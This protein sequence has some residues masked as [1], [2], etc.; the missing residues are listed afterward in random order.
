MGAH[1]NWKTDDPAL[2]SY[3]LATT[4]RIIEKA[5][6]FASE[7]NKK[8]LF[9]LSYSSPTIATTIT[10][11]ERFDAALVGW[12]QTTGLPFVD[13][14]EAH[15]KDFAN[16]SCSVEDY[17]ARFY[18][19][20]Y[21]TMGNLFCAFA[22]RKPLLE[23]LRSPPPR[24]MVTGNQRATLSHGHQLMQTGYGAR[25]GTW[26]HNVEFDPKHQLALDAYIP[27]GDGPFP[28]VV[29][30]HGGG[31]VR[32]TKIS[33]LDPLFAPLSA[34][35]FAWFTV[36]YRMA[37]SGTP[38]ARCEDLVAD[39]ETA[40]QWIKCHA[41]EYRIDLNRTALCGE[42]AG[43]HL[44]SLAGARMGTSQQGDTS[45]PAVISFYGP[46]NLE[47]SV[48]RRGGVLGEGLEA[49]FG[50][51]GSTEE[52]M[53]RIR[54]GSPSTHIHSDMPPY[55]LIHGTADEQVHYSQ[56]VEFKAAM[57]EL[58]NDVELVTLHGARHGMGSWAG[59]DGMYIPQM[60]EWLGRKLPPTPRED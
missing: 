23:L 12:L 22:L 16:F 26:Y 24:S 54:A 52:V 36:E 9:V 37:G 14:L 39:V 34:A 17:L 7:R 32:G 43:G 45:L 20:H 6:R 18:I 40:I 28:C 33:Y 25:F 47:A 10:T 21:S 55:L 8:I 38:A 60:L 35:G 57:E 30:V 4:Q 3:A 58:G 49:M 56:S 11:G 48:R 50:V 2:T 29:L 27:P 1:K 41:A 31:F 42:S 13:L 53:A 19:G 46:H 59:L 15:A 5:Y 51:H 44:V